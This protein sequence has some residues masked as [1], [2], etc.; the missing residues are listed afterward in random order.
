VA[1]TGQG[2]PLRSADW[3]VREV[4]DKTADRLVARFHYAGG[5]AKQSAYLHGLFPREAFWQAECR[6]VAHWLPP[7]A[8]VAK[9][10][11]PANPAGVLALSR[12]AVDEEAPG[13]AASFLMA[14]STRLIDR[15]R[16]PVLVTYADT[17]RGHTGAIYL[18]T[19][20]ADDGET[21]PKPVYVKNGRLVSVKSG[22]KTRTHAQMLAM[23]AELLGRFR[24]RRFV[25]RLT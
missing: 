8:A 2:E 21:A 10:L 14:A 16:W 3:C 5:S 19:G 23:G 18:A 6:G 25:L 9:S 22:P 12:L 20:W 1:W 13:N 15:A 24:K 11:L 4:D 17:W 7:I